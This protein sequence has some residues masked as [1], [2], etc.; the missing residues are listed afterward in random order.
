MVYQIVCCVF[1]ESTVETVE[2]LEPKRNNYI[3]KKNVT[4]H[5]QFN[6]LTLQPRRYD[7][8]VCAST[9]LIYLCVV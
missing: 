9:V 7:M 1:P 8:Y 3:G 4:V 6:Y 5:L 2:V